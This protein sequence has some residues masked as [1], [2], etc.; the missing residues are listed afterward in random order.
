MQ[1]R[2]VL[3]PSTVWYVQVRMESG[4]RHIGTIIDLSAGDCRI[5][6]HTRVPLLH[7]KILI[8]PD[9]LNALE[10][11]VRWVS[12][13]QFGVAFDRPIY[14]PVLE[15]LIRQHSALTFLVKV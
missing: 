13:N 4:V 3:R 15:H 5:E 8:K 11:T 2:H 9:G 6:L 7:S 1:P 12:G 10:G 14:G